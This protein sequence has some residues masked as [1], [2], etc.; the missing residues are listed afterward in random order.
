MKDAASCEPTPPPPPP[1]VPCPQDR[2][3]DATYC[4]GAPA[5]G[6]TY[7]A[8][9]CEGRPNGWVS[10]YCVSNVWKGAGAVIERCDPTS[11]VY[12][13][14]PDVIFV[15][16]EAGPDRIIDGPLDVIVIDAGVPPDSH[17]FNE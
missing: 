1:M 8:S 15:P 2:P 11:D 7:I 16:I 3:K 5:G 6:C 10:Y 13:P 12:V 4:L 9:Y 14:P 17:F